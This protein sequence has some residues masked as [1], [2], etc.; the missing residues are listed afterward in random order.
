MSIPL[1]INGT[2][3]NY[4]NQGDTNWGPT[5]TNWSSAVT[6]ALQVTSNNFTL[7]TNHAIIFKDSEGTPK[8]L[9]LGIPS[10]LTASW[11]LTLP[12][13][14]GTSGQ[15]LSTNGS[16]VTSW[17]N[18]A[19]GGTINSGTTGQLAYYSGVGTTLSGETMSGDATI[20]VGGA[21]T[22]A[23]DAITNVKVAAAAAIALSKLAPTTAYYWYVANASGVL[24][25]VAVTAS[26]AVVTDS[27]GLPAVATTT[28]T[29]IG[30]VNGV[31]S[32]IQA[33]IDA[34]SPFVIPPGSM[35]DFAGTVSPTGWLLC[36]GSAV[37]RS[38]YSA[39]FT[40]IG[41]TW[42]VGDG[43]TTFNL[44]NMT[45]RLGMGSGGSG[46]AIIGNAVGNIG[47][48]ETHTLTSAQIPNTSVTVSITDPTHNHNPLAANSTGGIT[49]VT[50]L[51]TNAR[52]MGAGGPTV[53]TVYDANNN[54]GTP[55]ISSSSTGI[56]A[57]GTVDGSSGSHNI[58]QP[59]AIVLKIIK[60]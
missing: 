38:T 8:T 41:V 40:A 11:A 37:S 15:V 36:D 25:P 42:G 39:L 21:L 27:N 51:D 46:T 44:P 47:G 56:T 54:Q 43:S 23:N 50:L 20:A 10:P 55:W 14:A 17:I 7:L 24:T 34:I 31:T 19:G 59:A 45:R 49:P 3:F 29:E 22:I 48:A 6:S 5:L 60:T 57:S 18:A 4:P 52:G 2:T 9:T 58:V 32:S 33:Q 13:S 12:V 1:T 30:Y 16:G 35:L 53:G 26:R 28:A